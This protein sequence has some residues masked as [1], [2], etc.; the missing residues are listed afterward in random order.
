MQWM[1]AIYFHS[2]ESS[3]MP[4]EEMNMKIYLMIFSIASI[5]L[6]NYLLEV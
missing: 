2:K 4:Y 3:D 5:D 1:I 6:L